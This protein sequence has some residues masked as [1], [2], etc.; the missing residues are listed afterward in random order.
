MTKHKQKEG[1]FLLFD[2]VKSPYSGLPPR[3]GVQPDVKSSI[4]VLKMWEQFIDIPRSGPPWGHV[5]VV[6]MEGVV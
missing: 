2:L 4:D 6:C 5:R 1:I 3:C